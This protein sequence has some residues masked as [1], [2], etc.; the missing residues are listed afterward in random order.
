MIKELDRRQ[1]EGGLKNEEE[2]Q[3]G[4]KGAGRK[5]T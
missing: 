1:K 2:E 3:R 4:K 5:E